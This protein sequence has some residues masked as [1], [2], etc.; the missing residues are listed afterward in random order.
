MNYTM[1]TPFPGTGRTDCVGYS[2]C[3]FLENEKTRVVLGHQSGGRIL[4]YAHLGENVL[5]LDPQQN[6]QIW[7]PGGPKFSPKAGRFDVGPEKIVLGHPL[8]WAGEWTA[9]I[10]GPRSAKLT[11][12]VDQVLELQ[13][14]RKFHLDENSSRLICTQMIVN[15]STDKIQRLCH[16]GRTL[17]KGGGICVIPLGEYSRFPKNYLMYGPGD[18]LQFLPEDANVRVRDGF[19]EI[20]GPPR[21]P[22]LGLDSAEGWFAYLMPDNLLF[23]KS[24]PTY[25]ERV[26]SEMAGITISIWAPADGSMIELEPIGPMETLKPGHSASFE[27]EWWLLPFQF[28]EKGQDVDLKALE[29]TVKNEL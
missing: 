16:W 25:P 22:K 1:T 4:E 13:L 14:V 5:F 10:T 26:Y 2:D 17:A 15:K 20:L 18:V 7:R 19:L 29:E 24:Y 28:P 6:G 23:L 8:L 3:I 11:S 12:Q 21:H 9:E 27:E